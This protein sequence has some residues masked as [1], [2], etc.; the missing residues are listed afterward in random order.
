VKEAET[1]AAQR[2]RSALRAIDLDVLTTI[3]ILQHFCSYPPPGWF[4]GIIEL[5]ENLNFV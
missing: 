4:F 3:W 5:G 2:G 1:V